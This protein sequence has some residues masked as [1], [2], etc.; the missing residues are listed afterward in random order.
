MV[1]EYSTLMKNKTWDLV[2]LTKGIKL[3][4]VGL[5]TEPNM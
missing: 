1:V 3:F 5:F 2:P 4:I